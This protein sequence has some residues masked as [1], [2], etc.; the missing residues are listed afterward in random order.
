MIVH[1]NK[2]EH[3]AGET[4]DGLLEQFEKSQP[5]AFHAEDVFARITACADVINRS[6]KLESQLSGHR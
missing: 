4:L 1:Q 2:A 5:V 3:R 6:F